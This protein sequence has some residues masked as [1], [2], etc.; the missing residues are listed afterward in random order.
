VESVELAGRVLVSLA[1]VLAVMWAIA[2]KLRRG[3]KQRS[4]GLI[5]ILGRQQLSRTASVAVLRVGGRALI[6]GVTDTQ[7]SVLGETDLTEA[8]AVMGPTASATRVAAPRQRRAAKLRKQT[9]RAATTRA[10]ASRRLDQ[11]SANNRLDP[12][13][14]TTAENTRKPGVL[15]GSALSPQTWRQTLESLRDLTAH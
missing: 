9:A 10:A 11:A 4:S 13:A 5:D 6:V 7:V 12:A 2:R 14:A 8:E 1:L 3:G 15:A